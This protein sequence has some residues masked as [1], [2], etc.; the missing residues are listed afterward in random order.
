MSRLVDRQ[1]DVIQ[2]AAL[3]WI[4]AIHRKYRPKESANISRGMFGRIIGM[5]YRRLNSVLR[6]G[7]KD[8]L[9]A[10]VLLALF[11]THAALFHYLP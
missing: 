11:I 6:D 4:D 9:D 3:H 1:I 2:K 5:W 7:V 8:A 10:V